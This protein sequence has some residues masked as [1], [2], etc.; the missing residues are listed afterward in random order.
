MRTSTFVRA[1]A[2]LTASVLTL[3][4]ASGPASASESTTSRVDAPS[5]TALS[6]LQVAA[7]A[8][9]QLTM[10]GTVLY[11]KGTN[12]IGTLG[13]LP[14]GVSAIRATVGVDRRTGYI[15]ISSWGAMTASHTIGSGTARIIAARVTYTNGA[16]RYVTAT[17]NKF[18]IRRALHH[19]TKLSVHRKGKRVK[20]TATN[21]RVFHPA[22]GTFVSLK[23]IKLQYKSGSK[24]KTKKTIKLNSKG[25]GTYKIKTSKK[26]RYRLYVPTTS[27][28]QGN[29]T[30]PT[31]KI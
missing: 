22:S 26:R 5:T 16:V 18:L 29:Y 10:R 2:M 12:R 31:Y 28:I 20:F 7:T 1:G 9:L 19:K 27:V 17:S 4:L 25:K 30:R 24:W 13:G 11:R 8:D 14:A 15:N 23:R 6:T 21:A 3:S